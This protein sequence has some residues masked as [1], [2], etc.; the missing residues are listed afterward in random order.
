M[1]ARETEDVARWIS[2]TGN[3]AAKHSAEIFAKGFLYKRSLRIVC[4]NQW[5]IYKPG[6]VEL[7]GIPEAGLNVFDG[8]NAASCTKRKHKEETEGE[9]LGCERHIFACV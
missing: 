2:D 7:V 9:Y 5:H 6:G 8:K 3:G 4:Q 1:S